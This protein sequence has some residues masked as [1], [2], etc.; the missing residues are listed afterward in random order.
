VG[1]P[2]PEKPNQIWSFRPVAAI[3]HQL[4]TLP[5]GI[6]TG[7][8]T[9][10]FTRLGTPLI[11]NF[12]LGSDYDMAMAVLFASVYN[13][14]AQSERVALE[15]PKATNLWIPVCCERVMRFN[16]FM[17][18][19]S[20]LAYGSLVCTACNKSVS[21]ELEHQTDLLAYGQGALLLNMLG[22]P[23]PPRDARRKVDEDA[24]IDD[25][26]L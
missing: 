21:F 1:F 4:A 9:I 23:K 7:T 11:R 18:K 12:A 16:V 10:S 25:T 24:A 15:T 14:A 8:A 13:P 3:G 6:R 26:T 19:N 2:K 17:L 5:Y 22:S 20:G